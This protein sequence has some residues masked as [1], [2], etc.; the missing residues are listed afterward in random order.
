LFNRRM[1][2]IFGKTLTNTP[3]SIFCLAA[4]YYYNRIGTKLDRDMVLMVL[5]ITLAFV[6]RSSS[7]IG[8]IPLA[9]IKILASW[10]CFKSVVIA[11][12][13]VAAPTIGAS[14]FFDCLAYGRFTVP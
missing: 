4:L 12:M 11:G 7:L 9:L 1:N 10:H 8:W 14:I 5:F 13:A 2:E 6:I 3:E